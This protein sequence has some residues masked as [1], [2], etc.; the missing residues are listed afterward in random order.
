MDHNKETGAK[1]SFHYQTTF[2]YWPDKMTADIKYIDIKNRS[3][4]L[5]NDMINL[6]DF[7]SRLLKIDQKL[8]KGIDIYYTGYIK[9]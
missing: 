4:Y 9:I 2:D 3:Y 8:Y 6:N 7:D 5:F 1:E